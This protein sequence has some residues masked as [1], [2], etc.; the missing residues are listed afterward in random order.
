MLKAMTTSAAARTLFDKVWERHAILEKDGTTLLHVGRHLVTDGSR[1]AFQ[2]LRDQRLPVR[3]PDRTFA[4]PDH[5]VPTVS[6]SMSDVAEASQREMVIALDRNASEHR[7]PIFPLG[8]NRQGIVHVVGPELGITLPGLVIVCGDS[9]TSTHGAFGALAFGIGSSEVAHVLATQAL[10]QVKPKA[11]RITVDGVLQSHATAKDLVLHVISQIGAAGAGGHVIEYAGSAVR[12]LTMEGRMTLCNMSIEAGARA[13]LVAPD[14]VTFDYLRGRPYAPQGALFEQAVREW[15]T[16]HSDAGAR[17]E[18]EIRIDA[19]V[20][21]PMLTWGTSPQ[22]GVAADGCVPDPDSFRDAGRR[23]AA[24]DSLAYMGLTPGQRLDSVVVD[25]VFI[26]SCTNARIEDLRAAASVLSGRRVRVQTTVVPGSTLVRAQAEA[27]GIAR[28]LMDAGVEWRESGCSMCAGT[29]GDIA[30]P[31]QRVV[32]TT[33]RN[34]VGR[35]G[36]NVRTHLASPITAAACA[37]AGHLVDAGSL[38]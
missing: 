38:P 7:I 2:K 33:N 21:R 3:R 18:K 14:E 4:T 27:E 26:G 9:H 19:A 35:Q 20:V 16:L 6:R 5:Y 25:R 22:D 17:F 37:V 28:V 30:E 12:A 24:R 29:N 10:W 36:K 1:N 23:A 34:F 8:D 13:G 11:L 15:R 31:G 32:S